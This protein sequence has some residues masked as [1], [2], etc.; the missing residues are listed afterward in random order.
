MA[1]NEQIRQVA[2]WLDKLVDGALDAQ[3]AAQLERVLVDSESA[4]TFYV[5]YLG[6]SASLCYYAADDSYAQPA[7]LNVVAASAATSSRQQ[8][9]HWGTFVGLATAAAIMIAV[10][11]NAIIGKEATVEAD[12]FAA[13]VTGL[14]DCTWA[15]T[16]AAPEL[17]ESLSR[18]RQ[19]ELTSGIVEITF[20]SGAQV[21][22]EGPAT[23]DLNSAWDATLHHG[24]LSAIVPA[25]AVG[26]GV[27]T[28]T[29]DVVDLGTEFG[30][31]VDTAGATD[32]CV[33]KGSV[34]AMPRATAQT[35]PVKFVMNEQS[36]RRFN[37]AGSEEIKDVDRLIKTFNK[38]TRLERIAKATHYVHWSF[39]DLSSRTAS[40]D[41]N[42]QGSGLGAAFVGGGRSE[43]MLLPGNGRWNGALAMVPDRCGSATVPGFSGRSSHTVAF[44]IRV[45]SGAAVYEDGPI[46]SWIAKSPDAL[47]D[48]VVQIGWNGNPAAG[49]IV[50]CAPK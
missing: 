36:G 37:R 7:T 27:Q 4:R 2:D 16:A 19:L 21:T 43:A 18:G 29:V 8:L 14:Q 24:K 22:L 47:P 25:A 23:L 15:S 42:W 45:P 6:L 44:W 46:A 26:F 5:R 31:T 40:A 30:M 32:L 35:Q 50:R 1:E 28:A 17:G 39:D 20:D 10:V 12:E 9:L 34:E 13:Q 11:L 48:H 49:P 38:P 33:L 41:G 3:E